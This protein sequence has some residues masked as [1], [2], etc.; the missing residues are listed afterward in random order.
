MLY[1][2]VKPHVDKQEAIDIFNQN[3]YKTKSVDFKIT[4]IEEILYPYYLINNIIKIKRAFGLKPKVI[5]HLYWVDAVDGSMLRTREVPELEEIIQGEII[6]RKLDVKKCMELA[7]DNA[8]KHVMRFYKSFWT[9]KVQAEKIEEAY[10]PFWKVK[11]NYKTSGA[12]K[13]KIILI[14]AFSG[15]ITKKKDIENNMSKIS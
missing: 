2:R 4:N 11:V 13:E 7:K 9:P 10:I 6:S 8:F 12:N 1:K 3:R 14:N 15:K 5:E